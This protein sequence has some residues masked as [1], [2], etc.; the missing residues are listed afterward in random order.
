MALKQVDLKLISK[1]KV[2]ESTYVLKYEVS[3]EME[4]LPGQYAVVQVSET[5]RR[6]Y[7]IVAAEGNTVTFAVDTRPGGVGSKYF[8]ST[9]VGDSTTGLFSMGDFLIRNLQPNKLF[10]ATGTGIAP[11]ISMVEELEEKGHKGKVVLLWGMRKQEDNYMDRL[12]NLADLKLDVTFIPCYSREDMPIQGAFNGRVTQAL[13]ELDLPVGPND[14][15][16]YIVGRPEVV[17]EVS[18]ILKEMGFNHVFGEQY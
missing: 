5:V 16:T 14:T 7:S 13:K 2:S 17:K 8:E 12:L 1:E 4:A 15:E 11:V 3:L 18:G 6:P 9:K 10:V